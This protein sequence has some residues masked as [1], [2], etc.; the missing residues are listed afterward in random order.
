MKKEGRTK[1]FRVPWFTSFVRTES[2]RDLTHLNYADSDTGSLAA[3]AIYTQAELHGG[4][5]TR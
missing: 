5:S 3:A 2:E 4:A 1:E